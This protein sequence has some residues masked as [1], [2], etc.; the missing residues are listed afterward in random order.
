MS[1]P[2][3]IELARRRVALQLRSGELRRRGQAHLLALQPALTWIDRVH[4]AWLWV[5][6]RPP[7]WMWPLAAVTGLWVARRPSRLLSAPW[8]LW[9]LW[10][11]WLRLSVSRRG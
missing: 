8:R 5:R 3:A 1:T 6:T 2:R 11:L 9:S 10:R 4:G 7:E